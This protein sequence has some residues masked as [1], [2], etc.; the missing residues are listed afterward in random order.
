M[1]GEG[2]AKRR[3]KLEMGFGDLVEIS[4]ALNPSLMGLVEV[5][6]PQLDHKAEVFYPSPLRSSSTVFPFHFSAILIKAVVRHSAVTISPATTEPII[7]LSFTV[8]L[9]RAFLS[10]CS[11]VYLSSLSVSVS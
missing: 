5:N 6:G 7:N 9:S 1:G 11:I 8:S 3:K 2:E 4:T 10:V